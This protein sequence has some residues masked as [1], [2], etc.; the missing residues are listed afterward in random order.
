M[1]P[2]H[3]G[4]IG[5]SQKLTERHQSFHWLRYQRLV[6]KLKCSFGRN[7][8]PLAF[9][10]NPMI[11]TITGQP[12]PPHRNAGSRNIPG[13]ANNV[14]D[15]GVRAQQF[16]R[17]SVSMNIDRSNRCFASGKDLVD[18]VANQI[19]AIAAIP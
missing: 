19:K 16:K 12:T 14:D 15:F 18:Q 2:Q 8:I 4:L 6:A 5:L 11:H 10:P 3:V 13:I 17:P 1:K 7:F 9:S